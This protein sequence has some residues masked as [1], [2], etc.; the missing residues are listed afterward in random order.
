M[1]TLIVV[2]LSALIL[3]ST[4]ATVQNDTSTKNKTEDLFEL[5]Q[6][7]NVTVVEIFRQLEADDKTIPQASLNEYNQALILAEESRSLLQSGT[8][9]P[10]KNLKKH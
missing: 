6:K 8:S 4:S 10:F 2:T 3:A 5:L 9:K 7:A 1:L